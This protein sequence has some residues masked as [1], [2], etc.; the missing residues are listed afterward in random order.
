MFM[1]KNAL[2]V[3]NLATALCRRGVDSKWGCLEEEEDREGVDT[4]L[5]AYGVPLSQV[6]SFKNI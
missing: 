2:N 5:I 1:P 4:S 6:T 3:R